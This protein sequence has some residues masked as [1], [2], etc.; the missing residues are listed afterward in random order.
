SN[1]RCFK[2]DQPS[3]GFSANEAS[4]APAVWSHGY[5]EAS[6]VKQNR[7]KPESGN[8][9]GGHSIRLCVASLLVNNFCDNRE[10]V[11]GVFDGERNVEVPSLLQCTM[12]DIL[13]DELQKTRSEEEYMGNTFLVMQR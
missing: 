3:C 8:S 5:A 12:C 9:R 13:A 10:A 7:L 1:I 2:V 11:Y 6:G 4:G